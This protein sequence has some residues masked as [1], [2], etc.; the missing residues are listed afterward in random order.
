M[1]VGSGFGDIPGLQ[2]AI[3]TFEQAW[4]WGPNPQLKFTNG[5]ISSAASD[6]TNTPTWE[7]RPG[8]LM[9][10]QT[11]TGTWVNYS[12]TAT[13]GSQ[14]AAGIII[15][16]LRMQD[17]FTGANTQKFWALCV[18]G[19]L[20]AAGVLG[21]DNYAR[22]CLSGAFLF[23]DNFPGN[24]WFPW[25]SMISKTANYAAQASDNFTLF[26]N[27]GAT[28]SVTITLP[29]I[30][31]GLFIGI[32]VAAGQNMLVTSNEGANIVAFNN[33]AANT[34]AFQT[35]G[36]L[37]GGQLWLFTNPAGTQWRVMNASAGTNTI[38]VS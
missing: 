22:Q 27:F 26:D 34:L 30:G 18:G 36:Q 25:K 33:A 38:T 2:Q 21:L 13:D 17:V 9:G 7:L 1:L 15:E 4:S 16:G 12:P 24:H 28:G 10:Q 5:L 37:I 11:A 3:E 35:G 19:N 20:R 23:D 32:S 29:P 31:P 8:L 6:P 14:V